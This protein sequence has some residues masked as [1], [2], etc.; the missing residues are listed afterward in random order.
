VFRT[1]V[2]SVG[3]ALGRDIEFPL[4]VRAQVEAGADLILA[5]SFAGS[6]HAARRLRYAAVSRTVEN[7]RFVVQAVT[8]GSAPWSPLPHDA[9]GTAGVLAP[10]DPVFGDDGV[11]V[12]GEAGRAGWV[13]A[14]LDLDAMTDVRERG[15][16]GNDADWREQGIVTG[17]I[18]EVVDLT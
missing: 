13:Y 8:I 11:V 12:E 7:Q 6:P 3:V 5:P 15:E 16:A 2:G 1:H 4:L 9:A 18:A 10:P 14:D 17:P